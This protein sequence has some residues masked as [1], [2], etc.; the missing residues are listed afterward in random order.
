MNTATITFHASHNYGSMLQAFALQR[1]LERLGYNNEIIN[2]RTKRQ[3]EVYPELSELLSRDSFFKNL[4]RK[5]LY[6]PFRQSL[7]TKYELFEK[8]LREDLIL[9]KEYSNIQELES[10]KLSY[11]CFI[12]G[13]DQ[14]WNTAPLDFDWSFY[15]PFVKD[16]RKISYAVSM[17]PHA[18]EQV[19]D[20]E[21]VREYLLDFESISV[22]EKG[23]KDL[24]E[25]LI[26]HPVAETLDPTLLLNKT[27][28]AEYMNLSP[29]RKNG[30]IF[31]YV[32][33]FK[34]ITYDIAM[35][36]GALSGLPVV[37][38]MYHP[39]MLKYPSLKY[40]LAVGPWE[41]LN[42]LS[43]ADLV[44]SG[45]FHAVVFSVI[46][47]RPFYAVNGDKDNRM[48]SLLENINLLNRSISDI[49]KNFVLDTG[50]NFTEA[51]KFIEQKRK[52]SL[53]YL[54]KAIEGRNL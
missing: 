47:N 37:T 50:C 8:F 23:T 41:F 43:N 31:V 22:R 51:E 28:W 18:E 38:S 7:N 17:G 49:G 44:V 45:S 54:S 12:A 25:S 14:I 6:C 39:R 35:K 26:C 9:T 53:L 27:E 48:K 1:T 3:R 20:R 5:I 30:Y 19:S 4:S 10:A 15:L 13:S 46:F 29:I 24:V 42:L 52:N 2:L 33:Y 40:E 34:E 36:I 11:D 21:K 32:P 16:K